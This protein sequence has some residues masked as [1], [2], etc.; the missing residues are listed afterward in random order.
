MVRLDGGV[1]VVAYVHETVDA[2]PCRVR[3]ET[4]LDRAGEAVLVAMPENRR[5]DLSDDPKLREMTCDPRAAQNPG[6]RRQVGA[7]AKRTCAPWRRPARI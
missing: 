7:S 6:H 1:N 4:S 2:A 3:I 5:P